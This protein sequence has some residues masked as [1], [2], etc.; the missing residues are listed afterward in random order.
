MGEQILLINPI[1]RRKKAGVKSR[2]KSPVSSTRKRSAVMAKR[3]VARRR[4]AAQKA[5]TRRLVALNRSRRKAPAKRRRRSPDHNP[6]GAP[7]R[8]ISTMS[9][10][11]R[12]RKR[13]PNPISVVRR[14][15]RRSRNP[16]NSGLVGS[17]LMPAVWGAGGALALDIAWGYL[18][19]PATI[20]AGPLRYLA[21]GAGAIALSMIAGKA[22]SKRNADLLGIGALTV[23]VHDAAKEALTKAAPTLKMDG[24]GYYVNGL[25]YYSPA[26]PAGVAG[27][28]LP[29]LQNPQKLGLYVNGYSGN[30]IETEAGY[31]YD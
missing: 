12:R 31:V 5:A 27:G 28:T 2:R 26:M 16:L 19:I 6:I 13:R 8:G 4:T 3:K 14:R 29:S 23:I 9:N 24:V 15:V 22:T 18:P 10:P 30:K 11:I 25:G 20:K 1:P 21:K 7:Y 17:L